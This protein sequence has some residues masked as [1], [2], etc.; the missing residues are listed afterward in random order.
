MWCVLSFTEVFFF[1]LVCGRP[2]K[3]VPIL[4]CLTHFISLHL[5]PLYTTVYISPHFTT[6]HL[7][8]LHCTAV[9]YT[10][11]HH[12]TPHHTALH[13]TTPHYT[14]PHYTTLHYTLLHFTFHHVASFLLIT[15]LPVSHNSSF[16]QETQSDDLPFSPN[17]S[18]L[19]LNIFQNLL[20]C[21]A[22]P[23][24]LK[25]ICEFLIAV[26]PTYETLVI[27]GPGNLYFSPITKLQG[28]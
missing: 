3:M 20:G 28:K 16:F 6:L 13:H 23:Q 11:A 21:P 26:H 27:H 25:R 12:S 8:T 4:F 5:I 18:S 17:T 2:V 7:T 19:H 9:Q 22:D 10:T 1:S 24:V 15:W 14:T